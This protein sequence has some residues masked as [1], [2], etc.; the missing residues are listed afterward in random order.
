MFVGVQEVKEV[1]YQTFQ[2][3][4]VCGYH[5]GTTASKEQKIQGDFDSLDRREDYG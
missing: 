2:A 4:P 3:R 1:I 5:F